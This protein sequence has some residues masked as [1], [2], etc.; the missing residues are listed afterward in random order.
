MGRYA[1]GDNGSAPELTL[2]DVRLE[3]V[4]R[5]TCGDMTCQTAALSLRGGLMFGERVWV[6]GSVG[7]WLFIAAPNLTLVDSRVEDN[8]IAIT[9]A[10]PRFDLSQVLGS[11]RYARNGLIIGPR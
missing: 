11:V 8:A 1:Q 9:L 3:G 4:D 5:A 10:L 6:S 7:S 2:R